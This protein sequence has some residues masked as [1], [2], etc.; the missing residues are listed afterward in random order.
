MRMMTEFTFHIRGYSNE[1]EISIR[2]VRLRLAKAGALRAPET[3]KDSRSCG[4]EEREQADGGVTSAPHRR[5][6]HHAR[7][8]I[9]SALPISPPSRGK[10]CRRSIKIG[11][12]GAAARRRRLCADRF[13]ACRLA[14]TD[15]SMIFMRCQFRLP[16]EKVASDNS[17]G[18]A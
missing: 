8:V 14:L 6:R 4:K 16:K 7:M 17:P 13:R 18:E 15:T 3:K 11:Q 1:Q 5:M 12:D 9:P 2:I 10:H